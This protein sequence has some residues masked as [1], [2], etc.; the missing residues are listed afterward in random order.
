LFFPRWFGQGRKP[1]KLGIFF[2]KEMKMQMEVI[3][4]LIGQ[5]SIDQKILE[6]RSDRCCQV[7]KSS[8]TLMALAGWVDD[9]KP[10]VGFEV[11][12]NEGDRLPFNTSTLAS[13]GNGKKEQFW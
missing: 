8:V 2:G 9:S 4:W 12:Y 6:A 10:W 5:R 1:T 3:A 7:W 11:P 13:V